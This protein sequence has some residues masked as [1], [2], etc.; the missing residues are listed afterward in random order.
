MIFPEA[1]ECQRKLEEAAKKAKEYVASSDRQ[2]GASGMMC[3]VAAASMV[4]G[5]SA[6]SLLAIPI[7]GV[8]GWLIVF[9]FQQAA[10]G[11]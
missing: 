11:K 3:V 10:Q 7:G 4:F 9:R 1:R 8:L 5:D 6:V 2:V